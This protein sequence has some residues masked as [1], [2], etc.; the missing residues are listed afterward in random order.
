M[1]H[2]A[3]C[4]LLCLTT[5]SGSLFA[6]AP[7][8]DGL[9]L[10]LDAADAAS[11]KANADGQISAWQDKSAKQQAATSDA[12]PRVLAGDQPLVRFG[13]G[14][15]ATTVKLP[16]LRSD[17]GALTTFVVARRTT[18]Q[19]GGGQWQRLIGPAVDPGEKGKDHLYQLAL[20]PQGGSPDA[21]PLSIITRI[22]REVD[23][24]ALMIGANGKKPLQAD[25]A[26]VLVYDHAFADA[27]AY[28]AVVNYLAEKW[29]VNALRGPEGWVLEG[30][31]PAP[32]S[33]RRMR[34][35]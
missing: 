19:A 2:R 16:A 33:A 25:V 13:E 8:S 31:I 6:A 22:S 15:S 3:L 30:P 35:R 1:I 20:P 17:R 27:A 14:K 18:E 12:G 34:C 4:S 10:W 7:P 21:F 11:I 32:P 29:H 9:V 28:E 26:E 5:L 23:P 24:A